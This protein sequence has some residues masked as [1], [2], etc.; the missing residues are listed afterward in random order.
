MC[1]KYKGGPIL[2]ASSTEIGSESGVTNLLHVFVDTGGRGG[3]PT[4]SLHVNG[5][6]SV[7]HRLHA[8]PIT[9]DSF[10]YDEC[11]TLK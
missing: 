3:E 8:L 9:Q 2:N 7:E 11:P 5:F 6:L 1:E 10:L 4:D